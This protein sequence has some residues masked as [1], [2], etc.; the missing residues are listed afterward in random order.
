MG[1]FWGDVPGHA[2]VAEAHGSPYP[3]PP[4]SFYLLSAMQ[5]SCSWW[6][7]PDPHGKAFSGDTSRYAKSK[8]TAAELRV[9]CMVLLSDECH[10]PLLPFSTD[11]LSPAGQTDSVHRGQGG[12]RRK[13]L[14]ISLKL[15]H[16]CSI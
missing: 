3:V 13:I 7:P 1:L 6:V 5:K 8:G 10:S 15:I 12:Q 4:G 9:Y 11:C 16:F 2:H 14:I